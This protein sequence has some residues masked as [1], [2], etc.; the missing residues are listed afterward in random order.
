[1]KYI[2]NSWHVHKLRQYLYLRAFSIAFY[3][4]ISSVK[5]QLTDWSLNCSSLSCYL[6]IILVCK[7]YMSRVFTQVFSSDF[8]EIS[9]K[10]LIK[11][12]CNNN[13]HTGEKHFPSC[14]IWSFVSPFFYRLNRKSF[15]TFWVDQDFFAFLE[16]RRENE[17]W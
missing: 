6:C 15:S 16:K 11:A 3:G 13:I 8:W 9:R 1:M 17:Y 7:W 12:D 5:V 14:W 10:A 4:K 2:T